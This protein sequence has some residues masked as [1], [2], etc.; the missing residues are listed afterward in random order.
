[1]SALKFTKDLYAIM[2]MAGDFLEVSKT[3][4]FEFLISFLKL[5]GGRTFRRMK[6]LDCIDLHDSGVFPGLA[7]YFDL[8]VKSLS[9]AI[10]L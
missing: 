6:F 9:K 2:P 4:D 1:M 8:F 10:L 7:K 5:I 3:F